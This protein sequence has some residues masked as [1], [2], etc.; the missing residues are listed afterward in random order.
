ML[1]AGLERA[2]MPP[3]VAPFGSSAAKLL[4]NKTLANRSVAFNAVRFIRFSSTVTF[5]RCRDCLIHPDSSAS[6]RHL[7]RDRPRGQAILDARATKV[8]TVPK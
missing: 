2:A 7:N 3:F 8:A 1:V 5:K 4:Q 6:G